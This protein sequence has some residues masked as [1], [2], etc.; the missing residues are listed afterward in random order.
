MLLLRVLYFCTTIF[1]KTNTQTAVYWESLLEQARPS[2]QFTTLELLD[3][4]RD[5][6]PFIWYSRQ[7]THYVQGFCVWQDLLHTVKAWRHIKG[8]PARGQRTYSNAMGARKHKLLLFFRL[9]QFKNRFGRRKRNIY[10]T[11]IQA[12]Y[13]NRLWYWTWFREWKEASFFMFR[14]SQYVPKRAPFDPVN[15]ALGRVNGFARK[16]KAAKMGK[17]KKVTKTFTIGVPLFFSRWVYIEKIDPRFPFI[18]SIADHMRRHMG[19]KSTKN[20]R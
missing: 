14:L 11:L 18:L 16:G 15:L 19:R 9:E 1:K 13:N 4:F 12:E 5:I 8:Y 2:F 10:P 6:L 3:F 20:K 7:V 17:A